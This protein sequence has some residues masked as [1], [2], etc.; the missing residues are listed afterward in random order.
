MAS[1]VFSSRGPS[2]RSA[3][4]A[5]EQDEN[6]PENFPE[7]ILPSRN[8]STVMMPP[9]TLPK[10]R[11]KSYGMYKSSY[12][13]GSYENNGYRTGSYKNGSFRN[14]SYRSG[15]YKN[16]SYKNAAVVTFGTSSTKNAPL[17]FEN[18]WTGEIVSNRPL[19][20]AGPS[21]A[22]V[23]SQVPRSLGSSTC[24]EGCGRSGDEGRKKGEG[25]GGEKKVF[26]IVDKSPSWSFAGLKTR[27]YAAAEC[28]AKCMDP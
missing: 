7:C 19:Y 12:R 15:I 4:N 25:D 5:V 14:G 26:E 9:P 3:K 13:N 17:R 1:P 18:V 21:E 20:P 16:G 8:N 23:V 11:S 10:R 6:V 22:C 24:L 2:Q 27:G 28:L